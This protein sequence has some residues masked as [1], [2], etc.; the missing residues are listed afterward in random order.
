MA[1]TDYDHLVAAGRD[2]HVQ[3]LALGHL[4]PFGHRAAIAEVSTRAF[5]DDTAGEDTA[6]MQVTHFLTIVEPTVTRPGPSPSTR[7]GACRW[8]R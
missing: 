5:L 4:L 8:P 3:V 2:A 6:V 1:I 7:A